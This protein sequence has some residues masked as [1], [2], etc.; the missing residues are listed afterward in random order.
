MRKMSLFFQNVVLFAA[1]VGVVYQ[2]TEREKI[3]TDKTAIGIDDFLPQ[4]KVLSA[5]AEI[6]NYN[7]RAGS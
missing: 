6:V 3:Q 1:D 2:Y 7:Q 5:Q 4:K